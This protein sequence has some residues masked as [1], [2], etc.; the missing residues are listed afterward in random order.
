[1]P[2]PLDWFFYDFA[3]PFFFLIT[4]GS[5]TVASF[6]FFRLWRHSAEQGFSVL[7]MTGI[8][9]VC[10]YLIPTI[11][12]IRA[13]G[14]PGSGLPLVDTAVHLES[15][16]LSLLFAYGAGALLRSKKK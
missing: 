4:V 10:L 14:F 6:C 9:A 5:L 11:D 2:S 15:P 1:M 7:M 16:V 13:P 12:R 3:P 8:V